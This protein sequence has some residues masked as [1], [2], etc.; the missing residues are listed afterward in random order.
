M[1]F[2][3]H[4]T[5]KS[6]RLFPILLVILCYKYSKPCETYNQAIVRNGCNHETGNHLH[7]GIQSGCPGCSK[8]TKV[9]RTQIDE[10]TPSFTSSFAD[11]FNLLDPSH[12]LNK[13]FR[14]EE[15][16]ETTECD[17]HACT[18]CLEEYKD[19]DEV[20]VFP[21]DHFCHYNCMVRYS[22]TKNNGN[23]ST[24]N[25]RCTLCQLN[26]L[27]IF[28]YYKEYDLDLSVSKFCNKE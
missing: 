6:I 27:R 12:S 18:I 14:Y 8:P 4:I 5:N 19:D 17:E 25:P 13:L 20:L 2:P 15:V 21:C 23:I 24:S 1:R 3:L 7:D 16:K 26:L 28:I 22:K 11:E 9:T 10:Y